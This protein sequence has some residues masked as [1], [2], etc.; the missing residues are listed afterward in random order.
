MNIDQYLDIITIL[1]TN[2]INP[3]KK[4]LIKILNENKDIDGFSYCIKKYIHVNKGLNN[5]NF[6]LHFADVIIDIESNINIKIMVNNKIID[7]YQ[8]IPILSLKDHIQF[9][10][11]LDD[12][13]KNKVEIIIHVLKFN[14][15]SSLEFKYYNKKI[16][17]NNNGLKIINGDLE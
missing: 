9:K 2:L 13:N 5:Y 11:S 7:A 1:K 10:T 15:V 14:N 3:S 16:I 6:D 8:T 17:T 4:D 12:I